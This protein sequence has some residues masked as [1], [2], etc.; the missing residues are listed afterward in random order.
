MVNSVKR[1]GKATNHFTNLLVRF[2]RSAY[3]AKIGGNDI[4]CK[5]NTKKNRSSC[6]LNTISPTDKRVLIKFEQLLLVAA[7][8][9]PSSNQMELQQKGNE[10]YFINQ[11]WFVVSLSQVLHHHNE[12]NQAVRLQANVLFVLVAVEQIQRAVWGTRGT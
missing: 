10:V 7:H 2:S 4:A 1:S 11:R 8:F 9:T 12:R 3:S 6:T 5:L